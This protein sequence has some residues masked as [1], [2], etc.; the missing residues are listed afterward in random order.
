MLPV[1]AEGSDDNLL[2]LSNL[3]DSRLIKSGNATVSNGVVTVPAG[4]SYSA[5]I[6]VN[7][8]SAT[9]KYKFTYYYS[10]SSAIGSS[11]PSLVVSKSI[12]KILQLV[13]SLV[14]SSLQRLLMV[15]FSAVIL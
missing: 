13:Q 14:F 2:T 4:G 7:P 3:S 1:S 5:Y 10:C 15:I 9:R 12:I 6:R 11:F 8:V